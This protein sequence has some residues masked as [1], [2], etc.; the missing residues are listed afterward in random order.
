MWT[1]TRAQTRCV[2][3]P[4]NQRRQPTSVASQP[5]SQPADPPARRARSHPAAA[6]RLTPDAPRQ[7][8]AC[9][10]G[11]DALRLP[12]SAAYDVV[13]PIRRGRLAVG[14]AAARS[15][16]RVLGALARVW[17]HALSRALGLSRA[18]RSTRAA[19]LVLPETLTAADARDLVDVCVRELGFARVCVHC[20]G[21]CVCAAQGVSSG[22]VCSLGA[23]VSTVVCV[24][25]GLASAARGA[26]AEAHRGAEDAA[27]VL[28][29]QLR[30]CGALPPRALLDPERAAC[31]LEVASAAL[32]RHGAFLEETLGPGRQRTRASLWLRARAGARTRTHARAREDAAGVDANADAGA[33]A[34]APELF[35]IELGE[36]PH[37]APHALLG[38]GLSGEGCGAWEPAPPTRGHRAGVAGAAGAGVEASLAEALGRGRALGSGRPSASDLAAMGEADA[39]PGDAKRRRVSGGGGPS[40]AR[41]DGGGASD[42]AGEGEGVGESIARCVLAASAN[43]DAREKLL[44]SVLLVGGGAN[45]EGAAREVEAAVRE[46]LA[47]EGEG[48]LRQ[49]AEVLPLTHPADEMAWRGGA[50]LAIVDSG[51]SYT[52]ERGERGDAW[53]AREE[54]LA[55]G[56]CVGGERRRYTDASR[57]SV[58][59]RMLAYAG[60][61]SFRPLQP[62]E[63]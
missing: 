33:A 21:A 10:P 60:S 19:V 7:P 54:W 56:V 15:R 29:W 17:E 43:A 14:G 51:G 20:E 4:A 12:P 31:D 35:E 22:V 6:A 46:A 63:A 40:A 23:G 5:A 45:T 55:R 27:R 13:W 8:P 1:R 47:R 62:A 24:E 30:A 11:D 28:A 52:S 58:Y 34:G 38:P 50:V 57:V 2:H 37:V 26:R 3:A 49:A 53:V 9:I 36:A 59:A 48:K 42:E 25:E 44:G 18:Q 39:S 41:C 32:R 61:G 16:A